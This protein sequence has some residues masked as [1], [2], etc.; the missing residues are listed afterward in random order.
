MGTNDL[1]KELR[2]VL[3][4]GRAPLLP[5]LSLALLAARDAGKVILDGVYNDLDDA[6]GFEAECRQGREIG[7]DGKTL[8]HPPQVEPCNRVCAPSEAEVA[9]ARE[10]IAAFEDAPSAAGRAAWSRSTAG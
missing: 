2:A 7:F 8:I 5:A 4:P 1:V 6:D 10:V 3:V 9:D